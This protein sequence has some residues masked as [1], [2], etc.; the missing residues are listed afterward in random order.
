MLLAGGAVNGQAQRA[1]SI[2]ALVPGIHYENLVRCA[3]YRHHAATG[4]IAPQRR[5]RE[6]SHG[7]L[8]MAEGTEGTLICNLPAAGVSGIPP[9]GTRETDR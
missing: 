6:G 4:T 8:D 5:Y 1:A 2:G 7:Q 3:A 9:A